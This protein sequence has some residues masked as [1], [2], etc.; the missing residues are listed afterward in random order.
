LFFYKNPENVL[1]IEMA[2][3]TANEIL[4]KDPENEVAQE[5]L[6]EKVT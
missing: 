3:K 1:S 5:V 2:I 4:A 6:F